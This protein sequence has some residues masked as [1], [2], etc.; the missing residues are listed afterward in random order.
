MDAESSSEFI[1]SAGPAQVI[2]VQR[3][4]SRDQKPAL[5]YYIPERMNYYQK[6]LAQ[7]WLRLYKYFL[8]KSGLGISKI[9]RE[10]RLKKIRGN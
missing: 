4:S 2:R 6:A 8:L 10:L 1:V 7:L 3:S 9:S 5:E